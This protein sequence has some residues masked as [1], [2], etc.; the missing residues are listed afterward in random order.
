[1]TNN[2]KDLIYLKEADGNGQLFENIPEELTEYIKYTKKLKFEEDPNYSYM[3]S[4]FTSILCKTNNNYKQLTFSW[5]N[6]KERHLLAF[7]YNNSSKKSNPHKRLF[8]SIEVELSRR[9]QENMD[10]KFSKIPEMYNSIN[11]NIK[12]NEFDKQLTIFQRKRKNKEEMLK[13]SEQKK[14]P[15]SIKKIDTNKKII[16]KRESNIKNNNDYK[17]KKINGKTNLINSQKQ[18]IINND[19]KIY[20]SIFN[21]TE[22][23]INRL[24]LMNKNF[25]VLYPNE[26]RINNGKENKS[27]YNNLMKNKTPYNNRISF[28]NYINSNSKINNTFENSSKPMV[29]QSP[30]INGIYIIN[31]ERSKINIKELVP[32]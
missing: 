9:S 31:R 23:E 25:I 1:V 16:A 7:K 21:S 5:I 10:L 15:L 8:K 28:S 19:N 17:Y 13:N 24:N 30:L 12:R 22:K 3:S 11:D 32:V 4:L 20:H 26:R 6:P 18:K 29:Y 2:Y 27:Y 14:S